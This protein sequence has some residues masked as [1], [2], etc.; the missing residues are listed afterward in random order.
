MAL[1]YVAQ[2]LKCGCSL[3][4][5]SSYAAASIHSQNQNNAIDVSKFVTL[6]CVSKW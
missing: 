6:T 5:T 4:V 3:L 1:L 2:Q